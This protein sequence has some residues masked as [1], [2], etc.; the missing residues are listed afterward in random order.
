MLLTFR[1]WLV[2]VRVRSMGT[3]WQPLVHEDEGFT[4]LLTH[5]NHQSRRTSR[6][7]GTGVNCAGVCRAGQGA[8]AEGSGFEKRRHRPS[9]QSRAMGGVSDRTNAVQRLHQSPS[10]VRWNE[11]IIPRIVSPPR[12]DGAA[13]TIR[14]AVR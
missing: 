1:A 5:G 3:S 10:V 8:V 13:Q 14:S 2:G 6:T 11:G 9:K 7:V 4:S 12:S